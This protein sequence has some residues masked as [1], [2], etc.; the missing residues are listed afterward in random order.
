[1]EG[2]W[3][4]FWNKAKLTTQRIEI[5]TKHLRSSANIGT[6][7]H[8]ANDIRSHLTSRGVV[9]FTPRHHGVDAGTGCVECDEFTMAVLSVS[10]HCGVTVEMTSCALM[11]PTRP[12][13]PR[14]DTD[15]SPVG[16]VAT[17]IGAGN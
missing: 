13:H 2:L 4:T 16:G 6:D 15:A 10:V 14:H 17:V 11:G 7:G 5:L 8:V 3:K 9:I 1:M 12:A